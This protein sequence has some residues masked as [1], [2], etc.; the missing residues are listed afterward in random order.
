M[1]NPFVIY[2]YMFLLY[3]KLF[4]TEFN[5]FY[6]HY[7]FRSIYSFTNMYVSVYLLPSSF[8]LI[9][10]WHI[11]DHWAPHVFR[12]RMISVK[13]STVHYPKKRSQFVICSN[14]VWSVSVERSKRFSPCV[15]RSRPGFAWPIHDHGNAAITQK[16]QEM[17]VTQRAAAAWQQQHPGRCSTAN[18]I[19]WSYVQ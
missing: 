3:S 9:Y 2:S 17:L 7:L 4:Y 13:D 14:H 12:D 11:F 6:I 18:L 16:H 5:I 8:V 19:R 1:Y 15:W 10:T